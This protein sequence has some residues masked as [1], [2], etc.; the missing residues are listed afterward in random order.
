MGCVHPAS[1]SKGI[2]LEGFRS[3]NYT[4]LE[5]NIGQTVCIT[6]KLSIDSMGVYYPLQPL[7][8][9]GIIGLGFSRIE[10][11]IKRDAALQ[12]G[13]IHGGVYTLCGSLKNSTPF[14]GC[15]INEC[16][17]YALIGAGLQKKS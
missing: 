15:D 13:L 9:D 3:S 6:G 2:V 4:V 14:E 11:G 8:R 17:W 10:T 1:S 12:S 7:E 5:K 16:K